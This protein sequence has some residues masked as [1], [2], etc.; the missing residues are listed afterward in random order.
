MSIRDFS[1]VALIENSIISPKQSRAM[2]SLEDK[3]IT[4]DDVDTLKDKS[5]RATKL[6]YFVKYSV[7]DKFR[8]EKK[9]FVVGTDLLGFKLR[10]S[11]PKHFLAL[12]KTLPEVAWMIRNTN[13]SPTHF[14]MAKTHIG[15]QIPF[16][17]NVSE[18]AKRVYEDA[19]SRGF[20]PKNLPNGVLVSFRCAQDRKKEFEKIAPAPRTKLECARELRRAEAQAGKEEETV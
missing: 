9:P 15:I 14:T 10:V 19:V 13:F 4:Y 11:G 8:N 7:P 1:R 12:G 17:V 5:I 2:V 16:S 18:Y 20:D 3:F 6:V